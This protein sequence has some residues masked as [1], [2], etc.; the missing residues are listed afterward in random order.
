MHWNAHPSACRGQG[1][2]QKHDEPLAV[3]RHCL[4]PS[5]LLPTCVRTKKSTLYHSRDLT[6][7]P[8]CPTVSQN[9][10]PFLEHIQVATEQ[11]PGL[12][13][14][15]TGPSWFPCRTSVVLAEEPQKP[16]PQSQQHHI[17]ANCGQG[18]FAFNLYSHKQ[19]VARMKFLMSGWESDCAGL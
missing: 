5:P 11:A 1:R 13:P 8:Q 3:P 15:T 14:A 19:S 9:S 18:F 4:H 10:Q 7:Q 17:L 12:S 6:L 16:S 2:L